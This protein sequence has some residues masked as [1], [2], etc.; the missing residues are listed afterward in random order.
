VIGVVPDQVPVDL[1]NVS[2]TLGE[3]LMTGG[4]LLRGLLDDVELGWTTRVTSDV[5]GRPRPPSLAAVSTTRTVCPTSEPV[6]V[7]VRFVAPAMAAQLLPDPSQ[8]SHWY[9]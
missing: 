7:Y 6:S 4:T 1:D 2:S 3:P 8:S 5:A 9:W